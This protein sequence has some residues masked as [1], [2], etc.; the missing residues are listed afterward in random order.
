MQLASDIFMN[1]R[2]GYA[3]S[4]MNTDELLW[5]ASLSQS[6]LKGNALTLKLEVFDILG[7]QTSISR[8]VN[9]FMRSD[10]HT[11]S[12]YQYGMLSLIYRFSVF[13][14]RNTMGTDQERREERRRWR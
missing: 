2:R 3:Q 14:G 12:I 1:S 11:N 8:T 7:Q 9:A 4:A 6:F 13:A 10:S 5:N